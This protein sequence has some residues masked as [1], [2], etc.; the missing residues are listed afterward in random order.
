VVTAV[1]VVVLLSA[2]A[3]VLDGLA[4]TGGGVV[5]P[6]PLP[7]AS[8]T[9][10]Q[11][12]VDPAPG[13]RSGGFGTS[14]PPVLSL[15]GEFPDDGPGTYRFAGG[16]GEVLGEGGP[17]HRFRVAIEDGVDEDLAEFAELVDETLGA[18]PGWTAGGDLRFQ[19]VP[20]DAAHDFTIHLVT[21]GTAARLCAVVG[22]DVV[23]SG[24]PD[25]GVSCRTPGQVVLNLSRWR[26]SVPEFVSGEVPLAAYRQMLLNHEVGHQLG[27]GHEGCPQRGAPAPVMQQQSLSLNGCEANP[28]PYVD[29]VRHT[30]PFVP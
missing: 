28:W 21:S 9:P 7:G 5:S 24:L 19:R 15:S 3:F 12:A 16:Q 26:L 18:G 17:V 13:A 22:L 20:G 2:M 10:G 4:G 23:G 11:P 8:V 30:G 29:G 6:D 1:L 25:G 14:P 27:H